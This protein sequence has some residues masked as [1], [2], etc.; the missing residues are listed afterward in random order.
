M[1]QGMFHHAESSI[2]ASEALHVEKALSSEDH[3]DSFEHIS[4][5]VSQTLP[6]TT[7]NATPV[8]QSLRDWMRIST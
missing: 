6:A 3:V 8:S 1:T 4:L 7:W 2:A 5:S